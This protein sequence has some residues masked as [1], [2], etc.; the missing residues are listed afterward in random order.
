MKATIRLTPLDGTEPF[1]YNCGWDDEIEVNGKVMPAHDLRAKDKM[2]A[3]G[4]VCEVKQ[5]IWRN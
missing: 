1:T 3:K 2:I 4:K 5:I